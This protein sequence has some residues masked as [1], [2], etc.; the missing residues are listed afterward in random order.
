MGG[1]FF[2]VPREPSWLTWFI[3]YS[4]AAVVGL[5]SPVEQWL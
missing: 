3:L 5:L 1:D 4:A 2:I